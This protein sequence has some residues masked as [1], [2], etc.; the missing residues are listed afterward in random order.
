VCGGGVAV[1]IVVVDPISPTLDLLRLTFSL[2]L[3]SKLETLS[4]I[5]NY[6]EES[7]GR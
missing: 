4:A 7:E 2:P 5:V 6:Q 1:I 3:H